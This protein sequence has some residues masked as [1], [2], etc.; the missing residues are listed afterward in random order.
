VIK[1]KIYLSKT[2]SKDIV[3]HEARVEKISEITI[4]LTGFHVAS[5]PI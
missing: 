3:L 1:T 4:D 5:N 2:K